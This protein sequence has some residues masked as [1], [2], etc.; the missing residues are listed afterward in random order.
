MPLFFTFISQVDI[1]TSTFIDSSFAWGLNSGVDE[2]WPGVCLFRSCID[3]IVVRLKSAEERS[4]SRQWRSTV[5][6]LVNR[7]KSHLLPSNPA[8]Q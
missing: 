7:D 1:E 4:H 8:R 2:R 5:R 3:V 6:K